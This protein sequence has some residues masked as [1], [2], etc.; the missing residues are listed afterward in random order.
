MGPAL[1]SVLAVLFSAYFRFSRFFKQKKQNYSFPDVVYVNFSQSLS[2][3]LYR[4]RAEREF[5]P[6][7]LGFQRLSGGLFAVAMKVDTTSPEEV[8]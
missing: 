8:T 2:I 5:A 7:I 6:K 4:L 3:D 1:R